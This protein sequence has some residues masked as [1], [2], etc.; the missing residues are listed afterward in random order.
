MAD[1]RDLSRAQGFF[2]D[3]RR[4]HGG[5]L[6][7]AGQL[8]RLC[9]AGVRRLAAGSADLAEGKIAGIRI[10]QIQAFP[11]RRPAPGRPRVLRLTESGGRPANRA[12]AFQNPAVADDQA[13]GFSCTLGSVRALTM[14]SGP[15]P[16]GSPMGI[17][18]NGRFMLHLDRPRD[19]PGCYKIGFP[20]G[21]D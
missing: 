8:D 20:Y 5:H 14:I 7:P 13:A 11:A 4:G 1:V 16:A 15:I 21:S 18:I 12:G 9:N 2:V 3:R 6:T 10:G 17:A 19:N